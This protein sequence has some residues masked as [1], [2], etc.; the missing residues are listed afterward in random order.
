VFTPRATERSGSFRIHPDPWRVASHSSAP[1]GFLCSSGYRRAEVNQ[2]GTGS[3]VDSSCRSLW[4]I[5]RSQQRQLWE[6]ERK[7]HDVVSA[8]GDL[9]LA[10][11]DRVFTPSI[12]GSNE[13]RASISQN[14]ERNYK[15]MRNDFMR[16]TMSFVSE[17]ESL[18][19]TKILALPGPSM[20]E[21]SDDESSCVSSPRASEDHASRI[22]RLIQKYTT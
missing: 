12:H 17:W 22:H 18:R 10:V 21:L 2:P 3:G 11:A 7:V 5:I 19:K 16:P 4:D 13:L 6:L 8:M 9:Q 15:S 1:A 14:A 20:Q